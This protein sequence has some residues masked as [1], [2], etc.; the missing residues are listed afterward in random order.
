VYVVDDLIAKSRIRKRTDIGRR[1]NRTI[2]NSG[3]PR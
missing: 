3:L 2:G 1:E